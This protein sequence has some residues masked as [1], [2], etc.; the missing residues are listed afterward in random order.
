MLHQIAGQE[1]S[2][3]YVHSTRNGRYHAMQKEV[4]QLVQQN[5]N[6]KRQI[7]YT[8]PDVSDVKGQDYDVKGRITLSHLLSLNA[9]DQAHYLICGPVKFI[10][11]IRNGL[12]GAG[13]PAAQLHYETF[14]PETT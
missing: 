2:A 10:S 8:Q 12:E 14:G 6:V 11:D 4:D 3:W 1:R 13:V 9:G 7:H 5:S